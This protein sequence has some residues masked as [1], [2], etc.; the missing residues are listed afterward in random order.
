M[1]VM[2]YLYALFISVSNHLSA[3]FIVQ[4]V[5]Q[6][7][8][9]PSSQYHYTPRKTNLGGYGG[10]YESVAVDNDTNP[11]KPLFFITEDL[12]DGALRRF[13]ANGKGW[14]SLHNGWGSYALITLIHICV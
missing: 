3:F 6:V 2:P 9:D 11:N 5:P 8:P 7:D 1:M 10:K 13:Q 12:E 4:S 14:N